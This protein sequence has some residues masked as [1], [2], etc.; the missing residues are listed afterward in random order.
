[1]AYFFR[2]TLMGGSYIEASRAA[3]SELVIRPGQAAQ[4]GLWGTHP[5]TG[6]PLEVRVYRGA[7]QVSGLATSPVR[8]IQIMKSW[9][10]GIQMFTVTGLRDGDRLIGAANG[11]MATQELPVHEL[12]DIPSG[13]MREAAQWSGVTVG[14]PPLPGI[15]PHAMPYL[16]IGDPKMGGM[17]DLWDSPLLLGSVN[18]LAVHTTAGNDVRSAFQMTRWGCVEPWNSRRV[19]AH[20]GIAGDGTLVQFVPATFVAAAQFDPGNQYWISVEVDN[21]GKASMKPKQLTSLQKLFR[22]VADTYGVPMK[23]AT[24][25]VFPNLPQFDKITN[26]VCTRGNAETTEDPSVACMARGLS[27][28]WWLEGP[29]TGKS[30]ACPGPGILDQLDEVAVGAR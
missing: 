19:S 22:W 26:R 6:E 3:L 10:Q 30:H 9:K 12:R 25:C 16:A 7:S 5:T 8:V 28:H 24:G 4:V 29:A 23:V 13:R 20:F 2:P 11:V 27:C 1:M 17:P 18:G 15:C 21:D 14:R